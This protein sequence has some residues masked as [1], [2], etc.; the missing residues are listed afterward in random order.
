VTIEL[1]PSQ[2]RKTVRGLDFTPSLAQHIKP[3]SGG[4]VLYVCQ[5]SLAAQAS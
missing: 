5:Q 4:V 3:I 2:F 1:V